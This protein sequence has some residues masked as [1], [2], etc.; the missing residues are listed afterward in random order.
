MKPEVDVLITKY[1]DGDLSSNEDKE[2]RHVLSET[3]DAKVAF[4]DAVAV[5]HAVRANA[6]SI[7]VP[8]DLARDTEELVLMKIF[9]EVPPTLP[10]QD[11]ERWRTPAVT[12]VLLLIALM[13]PTFT[14]D[15]GEAPYTEYG[16]G[17][18]QV[19]PMDDLLTPARASANDE[20][21]TVRDATLLSALA[22]SQELLTAAADNAAANSAGD[23]R[24][25]R[26]DAQNRNGER[27][28]PLAM[29]SDR[30]SNESTPGIAREEASGDVRNSISQSPTF[31]DP[32]E[33]AIRQ[34]ENTGLTDQ[35]WDSEASTLALSDGLLADDQDPFAVADDTE[36]DFTGGFLAYDAAEDDQD[37]RGQIFLSSTFGSDLVSQAETGNE[38]PIVSLSSVS[39]G[40][41]VSDAG[42]I[43]LEVGYLS[44][45]YSYETWR[46]VPGPLGISNGVTTGLIE[47]LS[48]YYRPS[49]N[50]A[51]QEAFGTQSGDGKPGDELPDDD[52]GAQNGEGPNDGDD[53]VVTGA[54]DD[55]PAGESGLGGQDSEPGSLYLDQRRVNKSTLWGGIFYEHEIPIRERISFIGRIGAGGSNEGMLGYLRASASYEL[56]NSISLQTGFDSRA[57][58]LKVFEQKARSK[59]D[60]GFSFTLGAMFRL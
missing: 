28:V 46:Y 33:A 50:D 11:P 19:D 30:R 7:S 6:D 31:Q 2:L 49:D 54:G 24:S 10:A 18:A 23:T 12:A 32:I 8:D 5:H 1:L 16:A 27:R 44:F 37:M 53:S 55:K 43:G 36:E 20:H 60:L 22:T 13:L 40:Y 42:R 17:L 4:D 14:T 52:S 48:Q 29:Q 15:M 39:L 47:D 35:R 45:S 3:P 21:G 34:S 38:S 57:M 41:S 25:D 58:Y 56:T 51:M 9:S 26:S 59:F